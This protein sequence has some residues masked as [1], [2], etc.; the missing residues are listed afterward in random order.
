MFASSRHRNELLDDEYSSC[1]ERED[2]QSI[3]DEFEEVEREIEFYAA[4]LTQSIAG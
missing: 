3:Q 1:N 2:I 4:S